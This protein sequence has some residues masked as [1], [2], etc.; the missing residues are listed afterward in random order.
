MTTRTTFAYIDPNRKP[1]CAHTWSLHKK[2]FNDETIISWSPTVGL[3]WFNPH[4]SFF[5]ELAC[6]YPPTGYKSMVRYVKLTVDFCLLYTIS[7]GLSDEPSSTFQTIRVLLR[8]AKYDLSYEWKSMIIMLQ[9]EHQIHREYWEIRTVFIP[10]VVSRFRPMFAVL[11][12]LWHSLIVAMPNLV[13]AKARIQFAP[14]P[15]MYR[16]IPSMASSLHPKP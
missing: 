4:P 7:Y 12:T 10:V 9:R 6:I 14:S 5:R 1:L 15:S 16:N 2:R 13:W 8:M 3:T 11:V